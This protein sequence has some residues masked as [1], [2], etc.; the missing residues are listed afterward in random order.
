[1]ASGNAA[2]FDDVFRKS[3]VGRILVGIPLAGGE[4]NL[5]AV[6]DRD[7]WQFIGTQATSLIIK[8]HKILS[9]DVAAARRAQARL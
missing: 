7:I 2:V 6:N 3:D 9:G 5:S 8:P 4:G 1:L